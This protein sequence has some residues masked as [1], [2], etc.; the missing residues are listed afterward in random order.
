MRYILQGIIMSDV[1][2]LNRDEMEVLEKLKDE[3]LLKKL[4]EFWEE[5]R[6][7]VALDDMWSKDVWDCSENAF[8]S[9][10]TG[11]EVMLP[12]RNREVAMHANG[13]GIPHEPRI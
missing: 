6:C 9:G 1:N 10:K 4:H 12:T 13:G 2:A 3:E 8:P 7:L 5:R 11:S